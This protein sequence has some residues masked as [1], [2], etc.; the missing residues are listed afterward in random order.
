MDGEEITK[1]RRDIAFMLQKDLLFPWRN[2]TANVELG[3]E[4]RHTPK[5]ERRRRALD[6][7]AQ[8]KLERFAGH[9]P[10]EASG[11][12]R[13]RAALAR[14]LAVEPQLLLL[15][16]PFSALDAQTKVLLRGDL[17]AMLAERQ[18][19]TLLITHDITEALALSDRVLV[20]SH[21]PGTII[22]EIIVDLPNRGDPFRRSLDPG[23]AAYTAE[24]WQLLRVTEA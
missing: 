5:P 9:R 21:R 7:L 14:T 19:T 22:S 16:E 1:P 11:G 17:A 23:V 6:L 12:M 4:I 15:D 18:R 2:L 24:I 20:M 8:C 13:Q 10:W 3:P